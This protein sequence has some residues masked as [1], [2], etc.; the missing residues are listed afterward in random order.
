MDISKSQRKLE[1]KKKEN[2]RK[3]PQIQNKCVVLWNIH[4]C[5]CFSSHS[6]ILHVKASGIAADYDGCL[7]YLIYFDGLNFWLLEGERIGKSV[8]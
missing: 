3:K 7:H 1:V 8:S 5:V 4:F 6:W 2:E